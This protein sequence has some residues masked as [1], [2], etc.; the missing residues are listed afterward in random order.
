MICSPPKASSKSGISWISSPVAMAASAHA[1][2]GAPILDV[3]PSIWT[4]FLFLVGAIAMRG[5][6]CVY[7]DVVDRD[8]DRRVARTAVRP[9]ASGAVSLKAVRGSPAA[10]KRGN[11]EIQLRGLC[12]ACT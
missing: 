3:L 2:P 5:A 4:L 10:L 8:L 12:D 1:Q 11:L 6:G 9:L 7:N